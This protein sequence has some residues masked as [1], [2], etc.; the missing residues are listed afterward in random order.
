MLES[1]VDFV[2]TIVFGHAYLT[3]GFFTPLGG[4]FIEA[5]FT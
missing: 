3:P 4:A 2:S 5:L 1:L